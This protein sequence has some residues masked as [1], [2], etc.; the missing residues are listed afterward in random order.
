VS[1][2]NRTANVLHPSRAAMRISVLHMAMEEA[3]E[4]QHQGGGK[5]GGSRV[6]VRAS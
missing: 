6:F 4:E 5:K 1:F 3:A 2:A